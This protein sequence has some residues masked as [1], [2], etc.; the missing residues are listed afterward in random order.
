M[1]T[2]EQIYAA[3][4]TLAST[5]TW[6]ASKTFVFTSRRVRLWDD[7][8]AVPALCQGEHAET[9]SQATRM[10]PRRTLTAEWYVYQ[11]IG[12]DP[13]AIPATENNNIL[14]AIEAVFVPTFADPGFPDQR[15]TLGGLVH[16]CW[17]DGNILKVPGDIDGDGLL[18]VPIHMLVP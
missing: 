12:K 8:P 11:R 1:A 13:A 5:V 16:H 4:F 18:V 17:I 2:R 7:L 6:G 15:L 10:P 14:D 9:V 3:L